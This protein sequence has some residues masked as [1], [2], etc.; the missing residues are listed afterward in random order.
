MKK[1]LRWESRDLIGGSG[2]SL[3]K[4]YLIFWCF[5]LS[6]DP[7]GFNWGPMLKFLHY[8]LVLQVS[9]YFWVSWMQKGLRWELR[10][11][12]GGSGHSLVKDYLKF[13]CFNVSG[14]PFDFNWGPMLNFFHNHLV[15]KV[16]D[17][18]WVF[19]MQKGVEMG[20]QGPPHWRFRSFIGERLP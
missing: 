18:F 15:L 6:G 3:V 14:N 8:H 4:D 2:H 5:N 13:W 11:L 19:W 12:I 16:S 7:F 20:V 9:D 17:Y 1:G 10:D